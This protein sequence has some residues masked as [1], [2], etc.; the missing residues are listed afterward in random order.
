MTKIPVVVILF[1]GVLLSFFS[2]YLQE[3]K[4]PFFQGFFYVG[5]IFITWGI[6]RIIIG[7][8]FGSSKKKKKATKAFGAEKEV[9]QNIYCPR[10]RS[11][12]I[13]NAK[14]CQMCGYRLR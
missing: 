4:D 8:I 14:Y 6:I 3:G 11:E 2:K 12:N 10:C 13:V 5:L 1:F 7:I 9:L